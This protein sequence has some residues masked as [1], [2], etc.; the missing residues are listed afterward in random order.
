[1]LTG[2]V[3]TRNIEVNLMTRSV[4]AFAHYNNTP[5]IGDLMCAPYHYFSFAE[6]RVYDVSEKIEPCE[7]VIFGGGAIEPLL[8]SD[9]IH[10]RVDA[11]TKIA[12]GIGTSRRG[13]TEHG[14]LVDDL[15]LV[16]VREYGREK[17]ASRAFYVPC[18]SCMSKEF[19]KHRE[20]KHAIAFYT[21]G[22]FPIE[23]PAG[24]PHLNNRAQ[25]LEEAI[26]FIGAAETIV[27]NSFHGTYWSLLLGKKVVC[28][29]FSSK[30]YGF[31]FAPAYAVDGDWKSAARNA[32][33]APEYLE[34]SR[35]ENIK[36][37]DRVRSMISVRRRR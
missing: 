9:G 30:F 36:F 8:R 33:R 14:P 7:A 18:V 21:H 6:K 24:V 17:N 25:T 22:H 13:R 35:A 4:I 11:R 23:V 1:M 19:D 16:G 2:R 12:W 29:P 37:Y 5:N 32:I 3:A 28:L 34:D 10:R 20:E 26:G 31:K 27:T 15:D